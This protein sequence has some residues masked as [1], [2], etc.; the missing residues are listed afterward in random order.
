M[1]GPFWTGMLYWNTEQ[2]KIKCI[3]KVR[4]LS[5]GNVGAIWNFIR[6]VNISNQSQREYYKWWQS[7]SS[8]LLKK[9]LRSPWP[10][11]RHG[12]R[13]PHQLFI[14]RTFSMINFWLH[15]CINMDVT[16]STRCLWHSQSPWL[17][18]NL[19]PWVCKLCRNAAL[20]TPTVP[21]NASHLS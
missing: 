20:W 14:H 3:Q 4:R 15:C 12:K 13:P 8:I 11:G 6:R 19:L 21:G 16:S 10:Q 7:S 5:Y 2:W 9:R 18:Q 17:T 1:S